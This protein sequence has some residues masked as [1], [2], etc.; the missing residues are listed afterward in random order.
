MWR[1]VLHG[2]SK[3]AAVGSI[4]EQELAF[5]RGIEET[6][7]ALATRLQTVCDVAARTVSEPEE[8]LGLIGPMGPSIP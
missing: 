1:P 6:K 4:Q 5:G 7:P 3:G 8:E 2:T